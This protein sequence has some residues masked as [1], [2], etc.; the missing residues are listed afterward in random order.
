VLLG[1]DRLLIRGNHHQVGFD[2]VD[3]GDDAVIG[4]MEDAAVRTS[5]MPPA[6]I[7]SSTR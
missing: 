4:R 6:P 7:F 5:P 3:R 2:D 1:D